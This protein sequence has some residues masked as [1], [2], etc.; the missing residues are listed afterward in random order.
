LSINL[1]SGGRSSELKKIKSSLQKTFAEQI[2]FLPV[3]NKGNVIAI[4]LNFQFCLLNRD[5]HQERANKLESKYEIEFVEFLNKL[6][7]HH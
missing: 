1:W 3:P 7:N 6:V 2:Y 4:L 5:M